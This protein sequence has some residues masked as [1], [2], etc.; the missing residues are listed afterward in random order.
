[1]YKM[2]LNLY[3]PGEKEGYFCFFGDS[4]HQSILRDY[5]SCPQLEVPQMK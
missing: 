2:M 4:G 1:M 5:T 3:H